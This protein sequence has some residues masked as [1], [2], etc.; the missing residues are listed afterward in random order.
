[1]RPSAVTTEA[2]VNTT[3]APPTARLPRCT[4][5]QSF[6]KPSM[7]EY[8][9]IGDTITRLGSVNERSGNGSNRRVIDRIVSRV[10]AIVCVCPSRGGGTFDRLRRRIQLPV[11]N[12]QSGLVAVLFAAVLLTTF[13]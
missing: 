10:D 5:C 3:A 2:S 7:L 11:E 8:W 13:Q 4:R 1:M 9:H 12:D 6:A